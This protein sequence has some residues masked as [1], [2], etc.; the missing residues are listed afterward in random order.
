MTG[1]IERRQAWP[2]FLP[3]LSDWMDNI[4]GLRMPQGMHGI[5][6]EEKQTD[7]MYSVDAELPGIDPDQDVEITVQGD[8]LTIR[9]ERSEDNQDKD[10]S[11]FRYGT[12]IR[13][14]R[15]P[16]AP[17]SE[18]ATASYRNGVLTVKIPLAESKEGAHRIEVEHDGP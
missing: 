7:G 5:R 15:L 13:S 18:E 17:R 3:D 2:Q 12:F 16:V 8:V 6:V 11:E 1:K 14:V 4:P 9:A 10:R